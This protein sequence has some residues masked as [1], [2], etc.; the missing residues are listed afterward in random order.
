MS[1][2][3][4]KLCALVFFLWV[5]LPACQRVPVSSNVSFLY[6][7]APGTITLRASGQGIGMPSIEQNAKKNVLETLLFVGLPTS[8]N[9]AYRLPLIEDRAKQDTFFDDFITQKKYQPFIS[10]MQKV[11]KARRLTSNNKRTIMF[12]MTVNF[13]A[14]RRYLEQQG[15]IRKFGY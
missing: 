12:E 6:E 14:L 3:V 4:L 7:N 5:L 15:V 9:S 11:S 2:L 13:E 8:T 1:R 10:S